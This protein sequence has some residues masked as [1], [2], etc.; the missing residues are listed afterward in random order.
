VTGKTV[1]KVAIN[2]PLAREFDYLAPVDC[3][4]PPQPGC[5]VQVPFGRQKQVGMVMDIAEK[6]DL[7]LS[8]LRRAT[9]VIDEDPILA[10]AELWLIQFVSNYYQHPIGEVVAA[11]VPTLLRQGKALHAYREAL[12]LTTDGAHVDRSLLA[13]RAPR[14]SEVLNFLD[15][16]SA[17]SFA[18]LDDKLPGWRR[19]RKT[20]V[21][22][23]WVKVQTS[24]DSASDKADQAEPREGPA[25]NPEQRE[26]VASLRA[27]RGFRTTL[28][29]GVT[30]SGKTEVYLRLMQD[31]LAAGKQVLILVPEIGLTSQFVTR[32]KE[33]IGV[34]PALLHSGLTDSERLVAWRSARSGSAS[35][36]LGT[37]SAVFVP[38]KSPGL[39]VVD[40]EHDASFK[41]QEGLRY[42][43]RDLAIARGKHLDIPVVLGSATPSLESLRHATE[44]AYQHL[45]LKSRAGSAVPPLMRLVDIHKH[46]VEDGLSA[47]LVAA[48]NAH[49]SR[50]NQALLFINRRGFAPT[51]ICTECGHMAECQRC[52]SRMTVHRG[53]ASLACH[54]CGA[55]RA[56]DSR[57][58]DCGGTSVPLGQGTERIEDALGAHFPAHSITR[59]DSDSTRLKGTM[60]KAFARA[61]SGEAKIL[62]GTQ[63]LSKGHHF[64]NLTLVGVI[65]ADQG[66]FST[67]FRG[68]ERLAQSLIQ[69]A[70]RAGREKQQGEVYIQTAFAEHSFWSELFAGGY[71]QVAQ[72]AM[73]EREAAAWPPFSH[74]ALMRAS[75]HER[76]NTWKLLH[77][78]AALATASDIE[79]VRI[80][81][82]VRAPMERKAGR[83]RGQLLL[84]S[85]GRRNLHQ[86]IDI[87]RRDLEGR[88]SARRV[89]W[90]ID[91]DPIELF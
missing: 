89:R 17:S 88:A 22:K 35:L 77:E 10:A 65:N 79:G 63:M 66:L 21:E 91:V 26:A 85:R 23:G 19:Q 14:Q 57:C 81:G 83:Y 28:L 46:P 70:G 84:Q 68:S 73:A 42:S 37:R 39:I 74:L 25:L 6:S 15:V 71:H 61:V 13:R 49:V 76:E 69:V 40:E 32:L 3:Q 50:G 24:I 11:A 43:A 38:L 20:L 47:P 78:V 27:G 7:P 55:S 9:R 86:L 60:D 31:V 18:T 56:L 41:Q 4:T 72:F 34:A 12:S 5:R 36:I 59:I 2:V 45:T 29:D 80:M 1:L 54:H 52:D 62:V 67:D 16:D 90:S 33:R 51:L 48:I 64:P 53:K 44:G 82:P 87:L 75:S 8:K 58:T 30:G